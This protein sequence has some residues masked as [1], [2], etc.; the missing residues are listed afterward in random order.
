ML[1][2]KA[3]EIMKKLLKGFASL[4]TVTSISKE[5]GVT[6]VGAWKLLKR[7]ESEKF[8]ILSHVGSGKTST[9][10]I[11]LNW[12]NP[13]VEKTLAILLAEEALKNQRWLANF[14]ELEKKV[15]FLILYGSVLASSKE[16]SDIDILGVL[17]DKKNFLEIEKIVAKMQKIQIKKIHILNFTETEFKNEL[18]KPNK[19]FIDA[20]KKGI[21][22]FGQENF[23]RFI[24]GVKS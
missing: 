22:L 19:A 15:D 1:T 16:A 8:I 10:T 21:V 20:I 5:A 4:H 2:I 9:Y 23:I 7:L 6:R 11:S 24:R 17:S 3:N 14:S 12:V 13:L 18:I